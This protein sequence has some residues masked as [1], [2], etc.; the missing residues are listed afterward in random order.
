MS[1][2]QHNGPYVSIIIPHYNNKETIFR[3]L[4][5]LKFQSFENWECIIVDDS[6]C[7]SSLNE[8]AKHIVDDLRFKLILRK[9]YSTISGANICRNLGVCNSKGNWLIFVDADDTLL[10]NCL[11]ERVNEINESQLCNLFIFKTAVVDNNGGYKWE[12]KCKNIAQKHLLLSLYTHS[13]P[14]HTMS[15]VWQREFLLK[16]GG[17]NIQYERL[18]DVELNIR[19]IL[20]NPIIKVFDNS[21]DSLYWQQSMNESKK[22]Y[23]R[24]GFCRLIK[25]YYNKLIEFDTDLDFSSKISLATENM[26]N[27]HIQ[28]YLVSAEKDPHWENLYLHTLEA[29]SIPKSEIKIV[30][31]AFLTK[32]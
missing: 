16:I 29:V 18:Q 32:V 21:F 24:F 13:I 2:N 12:F 30:K 9:N 8:L 14:W 3:T 15:V 31:K 28:S 23:A 6:S 27:F 4:E 22:R 1:L 7:E 19:A 20:N 26:L 10:E 11:Q 17:W 25:D 5:S